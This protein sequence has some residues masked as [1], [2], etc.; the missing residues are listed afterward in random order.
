MPI[1]GRRP[2]FNFLI[3]PDSLLLKRRLEEQ[4]TAFFHQDTSWERHVHWGD[5]E[6]AK[7]FWDQLFLQGMFGKPSVV[8]VRQAQQWTA[9][10]WKQLSKALARPSSQCL[11]F[12]CLEVPFDKG[13]PKIP[14]YIAKLSCFV[15]ADKQ[16]WVWRQDGINERGVKRYVQL[17]AGKLNLRFQPDAL[18]QFC[19]CLPPDALVIENEMQKFVLLTLARSKKTGG[20][21]GAISAD[22]IALCASSAECDIFALLRYIESG[23]LAAVLREA[24]RS[25]ERDILFFPLLALLARDMRILWRL[26]VGEQVL[27]FAS[28]AEA[29]NCLAKRIDFA[30]LSRCMVLVMDA[31]RQVKSGQREVDQSLDFLMAEM[32]CEFKRIVA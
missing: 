16:G 32:T 19:A 24:A 30:T 2:G 18:E 26:K 28:D 27:L 4:T 15:F 11:P 21:Q 3:C 20:E 22:M 29:K 14:A 7:A 10:V 13:N 17:R 6:P 12:F 1:T 8:I 9:A 23:N 31:E 5:E 25:Q